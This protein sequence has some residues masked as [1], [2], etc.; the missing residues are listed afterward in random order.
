[1]FTN[2]K[3]FNVNTTALFPRNTLTTAFSRVNINTVV[4]IYVM[5]PKRS[6]CR[7]KTPKMAKINMT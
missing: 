6:K 4:Y 5:T 3:Y 1:M 7:P 2:K